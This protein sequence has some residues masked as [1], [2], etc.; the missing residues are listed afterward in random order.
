M[1]ILVCLVSLA[2]VALSQGDP[3]P[4]LLAVPLSEREGLLADLDLLAKRIEAGKA[5]VEKQADE[6]FREQLGETL[7]AQ[8]N[9]AA[10]LKSAGQRQA[11]T[12]AEMASAIDGLKRSLPAADRFAG[13][14]PATSDNLE[15]LRQEQSRVKAE[16]DRRKEALAK[17]NEALTD[18]SEVGSV[19]SEQR[20]LVAASR[21]V[22]DEAQE[23]VAALESSQALPAAL[24]GVREDAF[25]K[26]IALRDGESRLV[27]AEAEA[28]PEMLALRTEKAR[29]TKEIAEREL[30]A[31]A[32][33]LDAISKRVTMLADVA[34]AARRRTR[35]DLDAYLAAAPAHARPFLEMELGKLD[36]ESNRDEASRILADWT[37]RVATGL[38]AID[39]A[40]ARVLAEELGEEQLGLSTDELATLLVEN[41][42]RLDRLAASTAGLSAD[43]RQARR[44][45]RE[46]I[47][48][49]RNLGRD[50]DEEGLLAA[51]RAA[52][53]SDRDLATWAEL[54]TLYMEA[55]RKWK[56]A[57]VA[58]WGETQNEH[59]QLS[60]VHDGLGRSVAELGS[61]LL[62]S[63]EDS[64]ISTD[65]L[66]RAFAD[67]ASFPRYAA[68]AVSDTKERWWA[69]AT[70]E[71][72]RGRLIASVI[73]VC[74]LL[75]L[76][77]VIHKKLPATYSWLETREGKDAGLW[78]VVAAGVRRSEFAFLIG[79]GFCGLCAVWGVWPWKE[80]VPAVIALTPF[81]YRFARVMLDAL[82]HPTDPDDRL[83]DVN[84]ALARTFHRS[85]RWM[86]NVSLVFV[87]LGLLMD[88]GGYGEVNPGL[89]QF[90]WFLYTSAFSIIVLVGVC[91]PS[92]IRQMIRGEGQV[93]A[94]AMTLVL[95]LYPVVIGAVL[96]L[97][98][99]NA[100]RYHEAVDYFAT[101]L[102]M[103]LGILAAAFL[104]YRSLLRRLLP[105]RD[106]ARVVRSDAYDG[107]QQFIAE[108]RKWFWDMLG[109]MSLRLVVLIPSVVALVTAW[110]RMNWAFL[111]VPLFGDGGD[112]TGGG[113][114]VGLA[115]IWGTVT[116]LKHYRRWLQ[117]L[118]LPAT[119]LDQGLGYA[120]L[121]L[122]SYVVVGIGAVISLNLLHVEGDQITYVVSALG[123]GIGLGLK[124]LVTNFISGIMLLVER[125]LK[126]GDQVVIADA[127]GTVEKINL[128]STTIM[129]FDNVGVVVPNAD[130]V[131]GKLINR[132]SGSPLLRTTV[133]VGVGYDSDVR[134]VMEII[135]ECLDDHGLV[136]KKPGPS[137]YF[138][139]FGDNS[140]DFSV[141]FWALMSD[142]R[143]QIAGDLRAAMLARFRDADVEIPFPQRDLHL[144]STDVEAVVRTARVE[145]PRGPRKT[146]VGGGK[147]VS[148]PQQPS[149]EDAQRAA[150]EE[151]ASGPS[152]G[153]VGDSE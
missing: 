20:N 19:L 90:W 79:L 60:L 89:I 52:Q 114:F 44:R 7:T 26:L 87:G 96:F 88:A 21:T 34:K 131:T 2:S 27:V 124:E 102:L 11:R 37:S 75:A 32:T 53:A 125:P 126:V 28:L 139:G 119:S 22:W 137:I 91:R 149:D 127:M 17:A 40:E 36:S 12:L 141:R 38:I 62:W 73:V 3:P 146:S 50:L 130:L 51:A 128:R 110:Q 145:P 153:T 76:F 150:A 78:C 109:R 82:F 16:H 56:L 108:G 15:A 1:R 8:I 85:G 45:Q 61:R 144:R 133:A 100:L 4:S 69:A 58:L 41:E 81:A 30:K 71:E 148:L 74:S 138:V 92:V 117:F 29:L 122:T 83:I 118:V 93:A 95:M 31:T 10:A 116:V 147:D 132:S 18:S 24:W 47:N 129:T 35:A 48:L 84:N 63:R 42:A 106:W 86:L 97:L 33:R 152:D 67:A 115:A 6:A 23:S 59:E 39:L 151:V 98:A 68:A 94:S 104:V 70:E 65:A 54:P 9:M 107:A 80:G 55:V 72:N 142:N 57:E 136:L 123:I 25:L 5:E 43:R 103:T 111:D 140:L 14:D 46:A 112:L 13:I 121:T 64:L 113:L 134:D 49:M 66:K 101:R 99:L 143:M 135:Q 120:I 77:V 105:D